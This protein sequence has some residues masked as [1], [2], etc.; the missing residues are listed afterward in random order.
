MK[1]LGLC[2]WSR[3]HLQRLEDAGLY[4]K[5]VH[6]GQQRVVWVREEI[7]AHNQLLAARL[8]GTHEP[9][10]SVTG[11]KPTGGF[12]PVEVEHDHPSV[13][14]S[15]LEAT[16]AKRF[17]IGYKAKGAGNGNI[18]IPVYADGRL[19][20]YVGVQDVTWLPKEWKA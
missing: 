12:T 10:K 3:A 6:L 11:D 19:A 4:P 17:G 20:G 2:P 5:R 15:G 9:E 1:E 14:V 8:T 18:L 16:D 7:E 13:L